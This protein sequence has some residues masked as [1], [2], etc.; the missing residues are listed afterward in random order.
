MLRFPADFFI[1]VGLSLLGIFL[2]VLISEYPKQARMFPQLILIIVTILIILDIVVQIRKRIGSKT[3]A[4]KDTLA[5][6]V[7]HRGKIRF[8]VTIGLMIV[9][10]YTILFFGFVLG[11]FIFIYL[12]AWILG[13][14][15]I[16]H[17]TISSLIITAFMYAVFILIMD[18]YFPQS[19]IFELLRG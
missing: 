2:L 17:L 4:T 5:I 19:M 9:F 11:T 3:S 6:A 13:Y 14:K 10:L 15:K 16:K 12:S 8:F 1:N 7:P 18:S